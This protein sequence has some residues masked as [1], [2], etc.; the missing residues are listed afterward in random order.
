MITIPEDLNNAV[1]SIR[2]FTD[3]IVTVAGESFNIFGTMKGLLGEEEIENIKTAEKN[4][5]TLAELIGSISKTSKES[6]LSI[7][8][9]ISKA[10]S[11]INQF[12]PSKVNSINLLLEN[13]A[14]TFISI[15]DPI[16]DAL[17]ST[18]SEVNSLVPKLS[19][20]VR[21]LNVASSADIALIAK[22]L[23][24]NASDVLN[25]AKKYSETG[26][27]LNSKAGNS[28]ILTINAV[29][30]SVKTSFANLALVDLSFR[31]NL[32]TQINQL[33]NLI[34]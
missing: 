26:N 31:T 29:S 24:D 8:N 3:Q 21:S 30:S 1:N 11:K 22:T 16:N 20:L 25:E 18:R 32:N 13:I 14:T 19:D 33:R 34:L 7:N 12:G 4:I 28:A 9:L 27:M 15:V 23:G 6:L 17:N 2:G 5:Y 10:N